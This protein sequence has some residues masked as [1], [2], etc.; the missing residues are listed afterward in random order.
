MNSTKLD[1]DLEAPM[2]AFSLL[3]LISN[4]SRVYLKRLYRD[5]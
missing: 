1:N 2:S 3:V 4:S 5:W